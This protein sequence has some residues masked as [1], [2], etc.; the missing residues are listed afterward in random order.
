M[1][2]RILFDAATAVGGSGGPLVDLEG[3]VV[4]IN[5]GILRA[6]RGANFAVPARFAAD[7]LTRARENR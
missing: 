5:Y 1:A 3:R 7:L 2:D 4:A 6:F